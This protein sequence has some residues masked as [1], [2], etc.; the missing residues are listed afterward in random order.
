MFGGTCCLLSAKLEATVYSKALVI[1]SNSKLCP[2]AQDQSL[3]FQKYSWICNDFDTDFNTGCIA[4][5]YVVA[6][7]G[8]LAVG[9]AYT[10]RVCLSTA[11]TE[12]VYHPNR[13]ETH[14]D[15]DACPASSDATE[16]QTEVSRF[17]SM[18]HIRQWLSLQVSCWIITL[19]YMR[20]LNFYLF[21]SKRKGKVNPE[22]GLRG[23][24]GSGRLRLPDF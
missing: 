1:T 12:M 17:I 10:M 2:T 5:R 20:V 9:N 13:N 6:I 4:Q 8:F 7:M 18:H 15:P 21:I 19:T 23:L 24:E 16:T 3:N 22:T 11:I 14:S